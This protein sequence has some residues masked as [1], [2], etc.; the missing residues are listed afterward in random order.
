MLVAPPTL[1]PLQPE[2]NPVAEPALVI[3]NNFDI[4]GNQPPAVV[5]TPVVASPPPVQGGTGHI[6]E[7]L[8]KVKSET[9]G[10]IVAGG[11]TVKPP[12]VKTEIVQGNYDLL[13]GKPVFGLNSI[14]LSN[15]RGTG[16]AIDPQ[17]EIATDKVSYRFG[18]T[19]TLRVGA[20][21]PGPAKEVDFYLVLSSPTSPNLFYYPSWLSQAQYMRIT[22]PAHLNLSASSPNAPK[23]QMRAGGNLLSA[24]GNYKFGAA[25]AKRGTAEFYST[26]IVDFMVANSSEEP[27][28]LTGIIDI[29]DPVNFGEQLSFLADWWSE[30]GR[31]LKL[32]ICKTDAASG[33]SCSGGTWCNSGSYWSRDNNPYEVGIC[34][35]TI[36]QSMGTG[37]KTYYA[38][39]CYENGPCSSSKSGTFTVLGGNNGELK[40]E[41]FPEEAF[42]NSGE[43]QDFFAVVSGTIDGVFAAPHWDIPHEYCS[44]EY[45]ADGT[46]CTLTCT[47]PTANQLALDITFEVNEI[48]GPMRSASD[49][50]KLYV[51]R[52][53]GGE[54]PP[55][56]IDV[57]HYPDPVNFGEQLTFHSTWQIKN[58]TK[59][60]L[61]ICKT[62]AASNGSCSG[63]TWCDSGVYWGRNN[64]PEIGI[65][66][67]TI[68]QSV[69]SGQ[70]TYYA[71]VC[72]ESGL[73]SSSIQN[74]FTVS[75]GGGGEPQ[76]SDIYIAPDNATVDE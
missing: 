24:Q 13:S 56:I 70:K 29:P 42:I 75:G 3:Q 30:P 68:N 76:C 72:Y 64:M 35:K 21:N 34:R 1:I 73:C 65:C 74:T 37:Q 11:G 36:D 32:I 33:G 19:I 28:K 25:L 9:N 17:I 63:D 27:P 7:F 2:L 31:K 43:S 46:G 15:L 62:N 58:D 51:G 71:F 47:N 14:T 61:I 66:R 53:G 22:L 52:G 40:V 55:L 23:V 39:L 41:L 69:G 20:V 38:F 4:V 57:S 18:D 59:I 67:T 26:S 45:C 12:A 16:T 6:T 44:G 8:P 60:K 10:N 49:T 48:E 5:Q 50:S 54:E